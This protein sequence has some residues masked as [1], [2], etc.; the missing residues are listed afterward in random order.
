MH[1]KDSRK[2][3]EFGLLEVYH[4][5]IINTIVNYYLNYL[6]SPNLINSFLKQTS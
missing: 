2:M 3:L 1:H 6:L 4:Y 5:L